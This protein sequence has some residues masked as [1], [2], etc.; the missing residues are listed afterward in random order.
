MRI[1]AYIGPATF[2][3]AALLLFP[4]KPAMAQAPDEVRCLHIEDTD[5]RVECLEGLQASVQ[6]T[7]LPAPNSAAAS[8]PAPAKRGPTSLLPPDSLLP[9][10][11]PHNRERVSASFNCAK[12]KTAIQRAICG[13]A[14]LSEWDSRMGELYRKALAQQ[15]KNKQLPADQRRWLAERDGKC[16]AT[17]AAELNSCVLEMTKA[18]L[19]ELTTVVTPA[20]PATVVATT[21]PAPAISQTSDNARC[22]AIEDADLRV[23]CLEG[24]QESVETRPLPA[25]DSAAASAPA[26][27]SAAQTSPLLPGK[28]QS[29]QR[30][31]ASFD[32][33]KAKATIQRAICGD[34]ALAEWDSRMGELYRQASAQQ[35]KNK[36][37]SAE[38]RQWLS[39]RDDKCKSAEAAELNSCVLEMT[40][41]RLA[42]LATVVATPE[43]VPVAAPVDPEPTT[44]A[45]AR[46][47]KRDQAIRDKK[48][49]KVQ[50]AAKERDDFRRILRDD[51]EAK[52]AEPATGGQPQRSVT[53]EEQRPYEIDTEKFESA[54][55]KLGYTTISSGEFFRDARDLVKSRKKIALEGAY[56]KIG[57]DERFF[58]SRMTAMLVRSGHST[59][60]GIALLTEQAPRGLRAYFSSCSDFAADI[61]ISCS[62]RIRGRVTSC[63]QSGAEGIPCLAVE[64]GEA[65]R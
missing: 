58:D 50:A 1:L 23:D 51:K 4:G 31:S 6:P 46:E 10:A 45:A 21:K 56:L 35:G 17:K 33:A 44:P 62:A 41:T 53:G 57:G 14:T 28:P 60:P 5:R 43:P 18:R 30:Y 9:S 54:D 12:A 20:E 15:R 37:L 49:P 24:A 59:D 34:A 27:A 7:P 38:Q 55:A 40:K 32:C 63:S 65:Q 8:G 26:P 19:A 42:E 13:D 64:G 47:A 11:K 16:Q 61:D 2:A 48:P 52:S 3:G 25:P 22:L 36:K 29:R 39:Q